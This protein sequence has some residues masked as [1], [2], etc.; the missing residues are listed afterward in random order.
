MSDVGSF[1]SVCVC[2]GE[3][4][5]SL[6]IAFVGVTLVKKIIQVLVGSF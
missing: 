6:V 5:T 2:V 3:G 1:L 4:V